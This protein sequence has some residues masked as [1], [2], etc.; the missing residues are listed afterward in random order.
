LD[1]WSQGEDAWQWKRNIGPLLFLIWLRKQQN[2]IVS[3]MHIRETVQ[4]LETLNPNNRFSPSHAQDQIF[5]IALGVS[6]ISQVKTKE[7]LCSFILSKIKEALARQIILC[8]ALKEIGEG[9][10]LPYRTEPQDIADIIALLWW[11]GRENNP[12]KI[13]Y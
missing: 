5:L 7:Y 8:D 12:D 3:K 10:H 1:E 13:R 2:L 9:I 11:E 4:L 6:A